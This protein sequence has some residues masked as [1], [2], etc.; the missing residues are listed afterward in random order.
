MRAH[1]HLS[2]SCIRSR[3][4]LKAANECARKLTRAKHDAEHYRRLD[5]STTVGQAEEMAT[6]EV[7]VKAYL[8]RVPAKPGGHFV[9][10]S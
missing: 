5:H 2:G 7:F 1:N 3:L 9:I 4:E 6:R 8:T 10:D